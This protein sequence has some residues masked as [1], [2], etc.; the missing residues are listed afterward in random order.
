MVSE[1]QTDEM[2]KRTRQAAAFKAKVALEALTG[3]QTVAGA[4]DAVRGSPDA[5]PPLERALCAIGS[6]AMAS[7]LLEGASGVFERGASGKATNEFAHKTAT[8][9][10]AYRFALP[11][12]RNHFIAQGIRVNEDLFAISALTCSPERSAV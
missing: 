1:K 5:D 11:P 12:L 9:Y 2:A 3:E 6:S 7:A 4:S 10:L 8:A